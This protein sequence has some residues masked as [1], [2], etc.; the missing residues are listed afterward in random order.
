[1]MIALMGDALLALERLPVP[2]IAA[3]GA[4]TRDLDH[5]E[6]DDR[7]RRRYRDVSNGD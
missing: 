4:D 7:E 6:R 3:I 1:M 2:T 5:E